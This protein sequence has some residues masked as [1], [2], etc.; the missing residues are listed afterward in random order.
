MAEYSKRDLKFTQEGDLTLGEPKRDE[1]GNIIHDENG[2]EIRDL[3]LTQDSESLEQ[4]IY[5]RIKTNS[6]EWKQHTEIGANLEDMI[7]KKNTKETAQI[8][9]NNIDKT[10]T[11]DGRIKRED[12]SIRAVPTSHDEITYYLQIFTD[13]RVKP[14]V[15]PISFNFVRGMLG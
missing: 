14:L 2:N 5:N 6:P 8:G 10:L 9:T 3:A 12:I 13:S 11:F 1:D 15:V 4:D 7:G